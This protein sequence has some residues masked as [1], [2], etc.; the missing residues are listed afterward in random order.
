MSRRPAVFLDDGGVMND[1]AL[2][3]P[4]WRRLVG[5]YL[6][7]RL[8][9]ER[10][11]WAEAN[12]A[13]LEREIEALVKIDVRDDFNAIMRQM[14]EQWLREMCDL[15]GVAAPR[16]FEERLDLAR[17]TFAYVIP[18]VRSAFPEVAEALRRLQAE[19]YVLNTASGEVST[20][21]DAYLLGMGVRDCFDRLYGPDLINTAKNGAL[22]YQRILAD[23]GVRPSEAVFVDDS[24]RPAAWAREAGARVVLVSRNGEAP[25]EFVVIR[26]LAELPAVL[27]SI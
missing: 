2:R 12:R 4:Q 6:A 1:N 3:G 16:E 10:A 18:R 27:E 21:L 25:P 13:V 22:Y 20:D 7:P 11:A 5:E 17:Q 8:G 26:S 15:V 14:D 19:G 24:P 23:S 9:G